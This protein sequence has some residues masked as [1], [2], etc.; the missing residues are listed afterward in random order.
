M[1]TAILK[2]FALGPGDELFGEPV[3]ERQLHSIRSAS[4]EYKLHWKRLRKILLVEGLISDPSAL[5]RDIFFDAKHA[6]R[7]FK[8]EQDSLALNEVQV[9]LNAG[10]WQILSLVKAG[11]IKRYHSGSGMMEF[12][13]RSEVDAFL[14]RL[15]GKAALVAAASGGISDISTAAKQARRTLAEVVQAILDGKLSWIGR[16]DGATGFASVLVNIEQVKIA[17]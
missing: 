1:K 12:F 7:I 4:L 6:D 11:I 3:V 15:L 9:Y 10:R 16:L 13:L 8:R 5:N 2:N 17:T 14:S